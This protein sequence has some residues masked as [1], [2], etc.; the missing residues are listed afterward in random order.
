[1]Y[2]RN[3]KNLVVVFGVLIFLL[4]TGKIFAQE[5]V[6]DH[7]IHNEEVH[8]TDEHANEKFSPGDFIFDH[9]KDS[10]EWHITEFNG[11]HISIPLPVLVYS[12]TKGLN[13]FM[14]SRFEHGHADFKG[15]RLETSG[16]N[17][18][19]IIDV[20]NGSMPLDLSITKNVV[21]MFFSIFLLLWIFITAGNAYKRNPN[22]APKGIQSFVEPVIL[23]IRD[24]VAIPS[25][26]K[27]MHEKFMPY[28]LTIFFFILI[29]N[30]LGLIPIPPGGAN[31]TGNIAVTFVLAMFTMVITNFS[32]NRSYWGHIF[33]TP[34][35]P[36]WLKIP[37]PLMPIVESIGI[38]TKPF[39]LMVR[40]FA[41]I[42]AGHIIALGFFSIIFIFAEMSSGIA[43]GVSIISILFNVF[44]VFLAQQKLFHLK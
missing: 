31:L 34:G 24:D 18:G 7:E 14:S 42:T 25:I 26:G 40:L 37:I 38:F 16:D 22:S 15:F 12:K 6:T 23:F 33:N 44:M 41:N 2:C 9:I 21:A 28:L 27:K 8:A 39:V 5:D 30:V 35:V 17:A 13:F 11:K 20:D 19:K 43:Y 36:V 32:G 1:M 10:H 3:Y 4:S 29:N